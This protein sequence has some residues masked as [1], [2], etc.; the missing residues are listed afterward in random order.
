MRNSRRFDKSG[1][2]VDTK[3]IMSTSHLDE[4]DNSNDGV[5]LKIDFVGLLKRHYPLILL[6]CFVGCLGAAIYY[7]KQVPSYQSSLA[8]HVGQKHAE[9]SRAEKGDTGGIS[10]QD[11]VLETHLELITSP[12]VLTQANDLLSKDASS[13]GLRVN[14][15]SLVVSR[16][17]KGASTIRAS[18]SDTN[19]ESAVKILLVVYET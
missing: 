15:G 8:V 9:L 13:S 6:G 4:F 16:S 10:M 2:Q 17:N 19:P 5:E 7:S 18:Y 3:P 14:A 12:K 11:Q 1:F